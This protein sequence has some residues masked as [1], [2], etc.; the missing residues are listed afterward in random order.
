MLEKDIVSIGGWN[1]GEKMTKEYALG[2]IDYIRQFYRRL[3]Y[4]PQMKPFNTKEGYE[5]ELQ[6]LNGLKEFIEDAVAE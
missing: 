3:Y 1:P 5:G 4:Q 2:V 6:V